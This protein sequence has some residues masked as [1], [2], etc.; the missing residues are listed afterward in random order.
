M[1]AGPLNGPRQPGRVG[2]TEIASDGWHHIVHVA[3]GAVA[4]GAVAYHVLD[5]RAR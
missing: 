3:A 5:R 4:A 1:T 2:R